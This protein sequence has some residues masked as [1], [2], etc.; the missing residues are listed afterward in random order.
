VTATNT[1]TGTH[2]I[3]VNKVWVA[4]KA[5]SEAKIE[6]LQNGTTVYK[7]VTLNAGNKWTVTLK[8]APTYDQYGKEYTYSVQEVGATARD[9]HL[10]QRCQCVTYDVSYS[11]FTVTNTIRQ[12]AVTIN[13]TKVW[14]DGNSKERKKSQWNCSRTARPPA[15]PQR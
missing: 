3:T 9:N 10:W 5:E 6:V 13:G 15:S 4:P 8:D 11:G 7:T 14:K 12:S 2:D 1:R